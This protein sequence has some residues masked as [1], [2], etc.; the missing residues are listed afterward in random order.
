MKSASALNVKVFKL[1]IEWN[2]HATAEEFVQLRVLV[3]GG[4]F[5]QLLH[6]FILPNI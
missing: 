3:G 4:M 6:I 5:V 1:W 2:I